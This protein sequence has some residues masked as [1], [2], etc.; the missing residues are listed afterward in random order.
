VY[1][2]V[3]DD[4]STDCDI[5]SVSSI[6]TH[7]GFMHALGSF[8]KPKKASLPLGSELN[9]C[10][11]MQIRSLIIQLYPRFS[12]RLSKPRRRNTLRLTSRP[13]S[14]DAVTSTMIRMV[15]RNNIVTPS[16]WCSYD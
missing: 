8:L 14:L 13:S 2:L 5:I 9:R 7:S 4:W 11:I 10:F 3:P 12:S 1:R 6:T 15:K 16:A